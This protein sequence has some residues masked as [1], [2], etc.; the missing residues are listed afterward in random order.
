MEELEVVYCENCKYFYKENIDEHS[1]VMYCKK[2]KGLEIRSP[3]LYCNKQCYRK[4]DEN[5]SNIK[6]AR[7][8]KRH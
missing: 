7:R 8:W 4:R 3:N 2:K 6:K 1:D 5:K